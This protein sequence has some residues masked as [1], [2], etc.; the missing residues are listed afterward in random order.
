MDRSR[1]NRVNGDIATLRKQD[2]DQMRK[3]AD[4]TKRANAA[5]SRAAKATSS[6]MA[7]SYL[8][9]AERESRKAENAQSQRAQIGK[10]IADKSSE[11]A[12]V[13]TAISKAEEAEHKRRI[14]DDAKRQRAYDQRIRELE[15]QLAERAATTEI[16]TLTGDESGVVHDFFISHASEDKEEFVDGLAAKATEAGLDVWYDRFTLEWGDSLRQKI[17]QG[18]SSAYFGVVVL[19]ANFFN[20]PWPQYEL[21]GL[22]QKDMLGTGRL[23]PIWHKVTADEVTQHT[24]SL[25]GRLALNSAINTTDEIV[26][27]LVKM[28][29]KFRP[30]SDDAPADMVEPNR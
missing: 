29:N 16:P 23:L 17:D 25:A 13:Q 5:M 21:D 15:I 20:K 24:P 11:A 3:E 10:K 6:S 22:V 28:R 8:R 4:A 1:L 19:S 18:L 2:A 14:A 12:R 26:A 9:E 27:E 30:R 7:A